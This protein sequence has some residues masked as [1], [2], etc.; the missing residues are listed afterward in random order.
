MGFKFGSGGRPP[1]VA[2]RAEA[3]RKGAGDREGREERLAARLIGNREMKGC[4]GDGCGMCSMLVLES[5]WANA[6][7]AL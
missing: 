6:I 7:F 3:G 4:V 5:P 1:G 2:A